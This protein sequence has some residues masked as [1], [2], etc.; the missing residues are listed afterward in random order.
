MKNR[1]I[2][3]LSGGLASGYC[4][5]LA[6]NRY[7]KEQVVLYFNDT[8]WEHPDLYRFLRDL[9]RVLNHPI[10]EDSDGRSVD[11]LFFDQRALANNRMPFCSRILKAERL[12]RFFNDGDTIIFGIGPDEAHRAKRIVESYYE[13]GKRTEKWAKLSFPLIVNNIGKDEILR[14]YA[15]VDIEIPKLYRLGFAHNNFDKGKKPSGR[16]RRF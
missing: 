7:P 3:A 5:W 15:S 8:R 4:A 16:Y 9:S 10:Y 6:L 14:W 11:A 13:Y 2:V 1:I 12:K